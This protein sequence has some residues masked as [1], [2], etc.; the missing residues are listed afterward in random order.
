M[1]KKTNKKKQL[2]CLVLKFLKLVDIIN[3]LFMERAKMG[4][5]KES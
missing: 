2:N 3:Q 1:E 4:I 5:E